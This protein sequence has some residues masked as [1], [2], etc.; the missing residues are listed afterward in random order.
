[1][2]D[3]RQ[4]LTESGLAEADILFES[5]KAALDQSGAKGGKKRAE[6]MTPERRAEI[7]KKAADSRWK[8]T[9]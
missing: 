6:N 4:L 5:A 8:K 1:M 3:E 2:T 9:N 7:A